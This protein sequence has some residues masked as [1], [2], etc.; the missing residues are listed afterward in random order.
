MENFRLTFDFVFTIFARAKT[1]NRSLGAVACIWQSKIQMN[2]RYRLPMERYAS[3]V[4]WCYRR[5]RY[6]W[7]EW[8]I[9]KIVKCVNSMAGTLWHVVASSYCCR[10]H[11][12]KM[13]THRKAR[14][15]Q[16]SSVSATANEKYIFNK[17]F[18]FW[19]DGVFVFSPVALFR[20]HSSEFYDSL[21]GYVF[22]WRALAGRSARK[23]KSAIENWSF[24]W[25][26][27]CS[28]RRRKMF[29][30]AGTDS[31]FQ[32]AIIAHSNVMDSGSCATVCECV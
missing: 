28:E 21:K 3:S 23:K 8:K 14:N 29:G 15:M 22:Y 24:T 13:R 6:K 4:H 17:F 18:S 1:L 27:M 11:N 19:F 16:F 20:L 30:R 32:I 12:V 26:S 2:K 9:V 7:E 31:S 10:A 25:H 5:S